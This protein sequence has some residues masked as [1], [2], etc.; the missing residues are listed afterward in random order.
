M[1]VHRIYSE[2]A[3]GARRVTCDLRAAC[4]DDFRFLKTWVTKP[5]TTGAVSPSGRHLA[6]AMAAGVDPAWDGPIVELGP[7]TGVVTAALIARGISPE[8]LYAIEYNG[9]FAALLRERF[10]RV[11]VLTGDAYQLARTLSL[12]GIDR[13]AAVVSSLPL[14]TSPA[15]LRQDL[16]VQ[17]MAILEPGHPFVQFSYAFVPPVPG[18]AGQWSLAVSDWIVLNLP[19]A[20]VWTYRKLG[21]L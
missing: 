12:H 20:R 8:R 17:S 2:A 11:N 16:L 5:L 9:A 7:G 21:P 6:R 19:P 1:L 15:I 4:G 14:F 10:P 18:R 3:A 13:A